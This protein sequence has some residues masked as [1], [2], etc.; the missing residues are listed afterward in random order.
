MFISPKKGKELHQKQV[1]S[2]EVQCSREPRS[3]QR[4]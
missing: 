2:T 3:A 4:S 1:I